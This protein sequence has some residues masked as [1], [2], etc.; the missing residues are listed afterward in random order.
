MSVATREQPRARNN[1]WIPVGIAALVIAAAVALW[2]Y[3]GTRPETATVTRRD[4]VL[5]LPLNGKVVAPPPARADI[6]APYRAPVARVFSSVGDR[7]SPGD[8][9]VELSHPTAQAAYD[10]TRQALRA[11]ETAY[12]RARRQYSPSVQE[13]RQRLETARAAERQARQRAAAAPPAGTAEPRETGA[14]HAADTG[15]QVAGST[16]TIREAT[17]ALAQA[18]EARI[19]AEQNLLQ[20]EAEMEAALTPYRQQL[21]AARAAFRE[22]QSGRKVAQVR[23]PIAGTVLALN[24]RPGEEIGADPDTPVATVVDLGE[25]QVH[26]PMSAEEAESVRRDAPVTLTVE[27]LPGREFEGKVARLTTAP[28]RPLRGERQVAIIEFRNEQGLVKPDMEARAAV[29]LGEARD[30]LAVPSEAV[31]RDEQGR[32]VV[33]V[34]REG[35]WQRVV[36]QPG[37]SDGRYTAIRSGL[38]ADEAVRVTPD[39]L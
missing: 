37:L 34:L 7:V 35:R 1:I 20:A 10:Q 13:A 17:G 26:A 5:T 27:K 18:I 19:A 4:I 9:L 31:D 36:V 2:A 28:P 15:T 38:E 33:E 11:A 16:V 25:L 24:A 12:E 8:V 23:S 21:E 22:A 29:R 3:L 32:P 6:G 30:V 39:L 14:T